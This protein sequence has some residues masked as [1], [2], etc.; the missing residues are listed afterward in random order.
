MI[1][2]ALCGAL[3]ASLCA[4]FGAAAADELCVLPAG[5]LK[6]AY[7]VIVPQ[8]ERQSG[9]KVKTTWAGT[10]EITRRMRGGEICDLA[11]LPDVTIEEFISQGKVVAGSRV[12]IAKARLGVAVGPNA[13]KPDI[14]T[15]DAFRKTVVS[16]RS[17]TYS[18]GPSG[19]AIAALFE[20]MGI[21]AEAK[22]KFQQ[23][24]GV[25]V[26]EMVARGEAE[27]GFLMVSELLHTPGITF[28]G[29]LPDAL[30]HVTTFASGIHTASTRGEAAGELARFLTAP[31]TAPIF[32][33][34]GLEP[35]R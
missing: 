22:A 20:R 7:E 3:G 26:V 2:G 12:D 9:H 25:P 23:R 31:A 11:I 35:A 34:A 21:A 27:I 15:A 10:A 17:L 14:A 8:F 24:P 18:G 16:A 1:C 28:V 30:Q 13:S 19:L 33:K 32:R 4:T 5:A 29:P 6:E